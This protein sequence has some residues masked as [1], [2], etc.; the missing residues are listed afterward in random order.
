MSSWPDYLDLSAEQL[1]DGHSVRIRVV[2]GMSAVGEACAADMADALRESLATNRAVTW[3]IPVGPVDQY[4]ILA[5]TINRERLSLRDAVLIN[6]DEYLDD[7]DRWIPETHPLSFRGYMQR[8]FYDLL[9]PELAPPPEHRVFPDPGDLDAISRW[10]EQ[11]GGVDI[12]FGGIGINGHVAFNEPARSDDGV[13]STA[14]AALPTRLLDLACETRTI[15]AN[16]VGGSLEVIPPR[17]VT[18]GMREILS[19][20]SL[21]F[22]CNRPWQAAVVRRVLH[23]PISPECPASYLRQHDDATLTIADY[24]AAAPDIRLR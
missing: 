23:G 16:T 14:F 12:C 7:E 21:K 24:V 19:A 6:M 17:C 3:I 18:V 10:I 13:T 1:A 22:Y 15:N 2:E 9:D 5:E 11:R 20:R 8:R 4:P